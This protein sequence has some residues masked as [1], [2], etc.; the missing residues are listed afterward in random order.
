MQKTVSLSPK[1]SNP[2]VAS[3]RPVRVVGEKCNICTSRKAEAFG[4]AGHQ[5]N[6][7]RSYSG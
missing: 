3:L 6:L 7:M 5:G 1:F 4:M 2:V